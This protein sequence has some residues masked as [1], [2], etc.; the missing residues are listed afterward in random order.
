MHNLTLMGNGSIDYKI[1]V[2]ADWDEDQL[3]DVDEIQKQS[4]LDL[5]PI[6]PNVWGFFQ[7]SSGEVLE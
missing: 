5:D 6:H 2:N 4:F 1:V 3:S 7:K